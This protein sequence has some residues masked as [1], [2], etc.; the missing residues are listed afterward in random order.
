M[1]R[2]KAQSIKCKLQPSSCTNECCGD[3]LV[4]LQ[5]CCS[6]RNED[7][8]AVIPDHVSA[9]CL[10]CSYV[11]SAE[12]TTCPCKLCVGACASAPANLLDGTPVPARRLQHTPPCHPRRCCSNGPT[13]EHFVATSLVQLLCRI[14]KLA[15][16]D[17]DAAKAI[18]AECQQLLEKGSPG[19]YL[20]S[21]KILNMLVQEMNTATPGRTL[22]QVCCLTSTQLYSMTMPLQ[23]QLPTTSFGGLLYVHLQDQILFVPA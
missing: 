16:F 21:L 9:P 13:M 22:T 8:S 14:I 3:A 10:A 19:H 5:S 2:R 4:L 11:P 23:T 7:V 17:S 6:C 18:V 20:L 1:T 15:W 12:R